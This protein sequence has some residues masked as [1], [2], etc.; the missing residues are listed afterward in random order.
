M[1]TFC[2]LG[3]IL[4]APYFFYVYWRNSMKRVENLH[5]LS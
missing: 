2:R 3:L 4:L 5:P 1:K